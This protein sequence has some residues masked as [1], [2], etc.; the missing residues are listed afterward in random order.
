MVRQP[1]GW[2][3]AGR[4]RFLPMARW[5]MVLGSTRVPSQLVLLP[6]GA[7]DARQV[8]RD[9]IHHQSAAWTPDGKRVVFVGNEPG[10]STATTSKPWD[11]GAPC[12][13]T[14][15]NVSFDFN[16]P[17]VI[18]PD[19]ESV[20][21]AVLGRQDHALL[22]GCWRL[23]RRS[24]AAGR[25]GSVALVPGQPLAFGAPGGKSPREDLSG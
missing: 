6:T 14:P 21:V 5:A 17:V 25:F 23:A 16:N 11:G 13:I 7:G 9:A 8:T 15:E 20:A 22:S 18:S 2:D 10:Q 12:A 1:F 19:G 24:E 4:C 3:L